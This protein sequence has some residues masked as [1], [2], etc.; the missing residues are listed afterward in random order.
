[1]LVPNV[2][3]MVWRGG[4]IQCYPTFKRHGEVIT[5]LQRN[6]DVDQSLSLH[7]NSCS[8]Y[9]AGQNTWRIYQLTTTLWLSKSAAAQTRSACNSLAQRWE[10]S[11][12]LLWYYLETQ[13]VLHCPYGSIL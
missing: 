3:H 7:T 9:I 2:E 10:P 8:M 4:A 6:R 13:T 1:M 12:S 11:C 5:L